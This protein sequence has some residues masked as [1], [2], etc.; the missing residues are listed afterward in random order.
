MLAMGRIKL[1]NIIQIESEKL[2]QTQ[3]AQLNQITNYESNR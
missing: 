3:N 2:N 1:G